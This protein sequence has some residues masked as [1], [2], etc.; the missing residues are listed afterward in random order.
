ML[1]K[2]LPPQFSERHSYTSQIESQLGIITNI[3]TGSEHLGWNMRSVLWSLY[4]LP[5]HG[6]GIGVMKSSDVER[7][8]SFWG[9]YSSTHKYLVLWVIHIVKRNPSGSS[10]VP[11]IFL[12]FVVLN[13]AR[14][15][16]ERRLRWYGHVI[17]AH[18]NSLRFL[19][20]SK[21][22]G[23]DQKTGRKKDGLMM[24]MNL[25]TLDCIQIRPMT[26][27]NDVTNQDEST[28]LLNG[29]MFEIE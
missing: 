6:R 10:G 8:M 1:A 16:R 7:L 24:V 26:E 3:P 22:M 14:S 21:L 20:P 12:K 28:P 5:N 19:W 23:D 9:A 18:E 4:A 2:C 27:G 25:K 17:R 13:V 15:G 11:E 29:T